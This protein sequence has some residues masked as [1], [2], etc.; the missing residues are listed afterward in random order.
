MQI[1]FFFGYWYENQIEKNILERVIYSNCLV[2]FGCSTQLLQ[3]VYS[4][5]MS[6]IN[7]CMFGFVGD[8]N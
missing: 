5:N 6:H 1:S 7:K 2:Y 3:N 8:K 4:N